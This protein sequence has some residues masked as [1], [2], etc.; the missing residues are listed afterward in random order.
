[1]KTVLL[2][3]LLLI[4]I[5]LLVAPPVLRKFMPAE[6]I[7]DEIPDDVTLIT[8]IKCV[9]DGVEDLNFTYTNKKISTLFY[10]VPGNKSVKKD[11]EVTETNKEKNSE[12]A[13]ALYTYGYPTYYEDEDVTTFSVNFTSLELSQQSLKNYSQPIS[14][15]KQFAEKMGFTCTILEMNT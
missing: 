15:Q 11:S 8:M 5:A 3:F 10:R 13:D 4:L 12:I 6:V 1:M 7:D 2:Y 9:R 14:E